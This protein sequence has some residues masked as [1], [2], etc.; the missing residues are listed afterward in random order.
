MK[1]RRWPEAAEAYGK[2]IDAR[3]EDREGF[4]GMAI[5]ARL[6]RGRAHVKEEKFQD[7]KID[8]AKAEA[9]WPDYMEP[10]PLGGRNSRNLQAR[11][12][13]RRLLR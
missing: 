3:P 13:S 7:A 8:F 1:D 9:L 11:G 12:G 4:L 5:E 2:L 6:G 10:S